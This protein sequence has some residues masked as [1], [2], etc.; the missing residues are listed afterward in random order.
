MCE[1]RMNAAMNVAR[2][3]QSGRRSGNRLSILPGTFESRVSI[4]CAGVFLTANALH[5]SGEVT[6]RLYSLLRIQESGFQEQS[7]H[8]ARTRCKARQSA[9]LLPSAI[10]HPPKKVNLPSD[11]AHRLRTLPLERTP[12]D[13]LVRVRSP[14]ATAVRILHPSLLG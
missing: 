11:P 7:A 5:Q 14:K 10:V 3:Q 2:T 12:A 9:L 4:S 13:G 8:I 6:A 1:C